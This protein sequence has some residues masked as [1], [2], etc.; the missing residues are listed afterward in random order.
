M[1]LSMR[2]RRIGVSGG[3]GISPPPTDGLIAYWTMD[4]INGA[5]LEDELN[6]Y[7]ATIVGAIQTTGSLGHIGEALN[8][9]GTD[10]YFYVNNAG[11]N[12][13]VFSISMWIKSDDTAYTNERCLFST[14]NATNVNGT[15]SLQ[16]DDSSNALQCLLHAGAVI[17]GTTQITNTNWHHVVF[18][19]ANDGSV[20]IWLDNTNEVTGTLS[21]PSAYVQFQ[22][23]KGHTAYGSWDGLIDHV[24]VYNRVVTLE[25]VNSLFMES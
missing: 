7:D 23:G 14:T 17:N 15:L 24:R 9:D 20:V 6:T 18:T 25:E 2:G 16:V 8:F 10:D 5:T 19:R 21:A 13:S 1:P 11:L 12:L 22:I 4:N 3:S